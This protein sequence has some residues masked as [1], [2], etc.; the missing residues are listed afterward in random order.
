[1]PRLK[2]N[3]AFMAGIAGH[4]SAEPDTLA[5]RMERESRATLLEDA[6]E[7]YY[8]TRHYRPHPVV[9][10]RL[11]QVS[12]DALRELVRGSWQLTLARQAKRRVRRE[13]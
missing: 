7:T 9:L 6:P 3:G 11:R 1:M 4:S 5:V 10:V 2:A 8:L 13:F 12:P